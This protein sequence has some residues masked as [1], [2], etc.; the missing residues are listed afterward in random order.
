MKIGI[1]TF[2]RSINYGAFMQCYALSNRLR[3]DFPDIEIEVIDYTSERID[4]HYKA[5]IETADPAR[6]QGRKHI[7]AAFEES[8]QFLPLS[9][10]RMCSD[11]MPELMQWL[12]DTY[13]IIIVGSDAVWNWNIRGFPNPYFLHDYKGIK[14]SYA[15]S[16]FGQCY[17]DMTPGQRAYL[18]EAFRDFRY[19][20]VRDAATEDML[21]MVDPQL[22]VHHN[23]DPTVLLEP[24]KLPCSIETVREKFRKKGLDLAKPMIGLMAGESNVGRELRKYLKHDVQLVALYEPNGWADAYLDDLTPFEWARAFSLLQCTVTHFFHGTMLSLVNGIPPIVAEAKQGYAANYITKIYDVLTRLDFLQWYHAVPM[25]FCTRLCKKMSLPTN[26]G[27]WKQICRDIRQ[28]NGQEAAIQ[29][30]SRLKQEAQSYTSFQ[31]ALED[32]IRTVKKEKEIG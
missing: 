29:I 24:E 11:D 23:C 16:A 4:K 31:K 25:S 5:W 21:H 30:H 2:Q 18:Q 6:N 1:L 9:E 12:N 26:R 10:R 17:R 8:Y 13:D 22:E 19:L 32:C 27:M 7:K 3:Q 14:L 15:A 28:M 20:G